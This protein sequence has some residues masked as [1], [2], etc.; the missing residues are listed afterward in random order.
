MT[1]A[2]ALDVLDMVLQKVRLND[3]QE[4]VFCEAWAG[5]TFPQIAAELNFTE[6]HI[7]AV[8]ADLWHLLSEA[9][10][11]KVTKRNFKGVIER[12]VRRHGS[13]AHASTFSERD[14]FQDWG[15]A[16]DVSTFF[17]RTDE[18]ATLE[19]WI[20][21][22]RCRLVA[23]LGMGGIGK[24]SLSIKVAQKIQAEFDYLIWRS[25]RNAP[26][27]QELLTS[28]LNFLSD[29]AVSLPAEISGQLS[30]LINYLRDRRCLIILD[31]AEMILNSSH[32]ASASGG[33]HAGQYR[34][35]YEA[36]GELWRCVGEIPHQS[37]VMLTSREKPREIDLQAGANEPVR[38]LQLRGL[39]R[40]EGQ[41]IF[42]LRG[43]FF[44][45][46]MDWKQLIQHY[47]GNP[48]ALKIVA[49]TIQ[50]LFD[51]NVTRFTYLLQQGIVV[52][53]DIRDL[54]SGQIDRLSEDETEV[55]C[56]LAIHRELV[57]F[58]ELQE[59][60]I[61]PLL[62]WKLPEVLRS[63]GRRFLIERS[64]KG[65]TQQP[66]V[67]EYVIEQFTEQVC[68]EI[69]AEKL[70]LLM[71]YALIKAQTKSYIRESQGRMILAPIAERLCDLLK[72]PKQ[73][74]LKL[75]RILN[76]LKTEYADAPGYA[77][78]NLINLLHQLAIDLTG[79]DFSHLAVWQAYLQGVRLHQVNFAAADLSKSVFTETLGNVWAVAFSPNGQLLAAG[80]TVNE[81]H[82]WQIGDGI[83]A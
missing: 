61:S 24:T 62:K 31:N 72:S 74:E 1:I 11:E 77:A 71:N 46:E 30:L 43:Q 34:E 13:I 14:Q 21:H 16:V 64:P 25:L 58:A 70:Y 51:S 83:P 66:V 67:M 7:R 54:I 63:L 53:D 80:D 68:Q 22:D 33:Q 44:G 57:S 36:Y 10:G 32:A 55:M 26:P 73:V 76:T 59:D 29:G 23:L 6:E 39:N 65:F 48:L 12:W 50:D 82:L 81:V 49:S 78:G 38:S 9:L 3:T 19:Y 75:K 41:E 2:Q 27:L 37:C 18:L 40:T 15:E 35:G 47:A 42:Q 52:F 56:W 20:V 28:L 8:G 69:C 4:A 60:I 17:G 5:K 79:Y 45:S